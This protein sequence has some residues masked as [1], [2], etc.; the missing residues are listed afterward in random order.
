[1]L[2]YTK[3]D[4]FSDILPETIPD[5][6]AFVLIILMCITPFALLVFLTRLATG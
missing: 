2:S 3:K 4:L 6:V 1:M 5:S